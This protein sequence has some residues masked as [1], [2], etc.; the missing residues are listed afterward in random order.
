MLGSGKMDISLYI[1]IPF[2]VKKCLYCDFPSYGEMDK[3]FEAYVNKLCGEISD[4]AGEMKGMNVRS[5][6][7][8]GGTPSVLPPK[9][10][11]K[12]M[13]AVINRYDVDSK[14][15]ITMEANPGTL[16][17][18][19]LTEL[20]SM[21][22]NRLSIG[23]QAW[24]NRLLKSI[25]RIHTAEEFERNFYDARAVGFDNINLDL[26]FSLPGQSLSDWRETLKKAVGLNPEHI[27][28]Y[29]LIIEEGTP[30][31]DMYQKGIIKE[32]EENLDRDMYYLVN[33]MLKENGYH[34]YEISNFAKK[35]FE[36]KH[37]KIY[38]RTQEYK[39]FGLGA[40]SYMDGRRF[41]NTYD[42]KEYIEEKVK[43][44][45]MELLSDEEKEEEF[46]FM[47]LRMTEGI[48][49]RDFRERFKTDIYNVYGEELKTLIEE[50]LINEKDDR[51]FLSERGID[52]SNQIFEKFI[53]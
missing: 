27:S 44:L 3:Y 7:I 2:C 6:F 22:F 42:F 11:G 45:D 14:A 1:H 12:I 15:E 19:K 34:R 23:L 39:G 20:K 33:A 46:M 38:W 37:N 9:L 5:I 31:Y 53:R 18:D 41:H 48:S 8:G 35:G 24:Q 4:A 47:G 25:G 16:D 51:I 26:M 40:H 43:P 28:A 29:S 32:T 13:D 49:K 10:M 21:Y 50:K 36:C 17:L 52:I 30:F